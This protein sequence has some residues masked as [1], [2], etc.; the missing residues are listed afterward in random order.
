MENSANSSRILNFNHLMNKKNLFVLGILAFLIFVFF[1]YLVHKD[2]FTQFDFDNTVKLQDRIT[3]RVDTP[4]STLSLLGSFEISSLFLL[5]LVVIRR[6]ISAI[7]I[8]IP[9]VM[10]IL[11]ELYGK[12]FVIH[13]GPPYLFLRNDIPFNFPS[14]YV[15]PGSSY[16]SGHSTRTLFISVVLIFMIA[17]SKK[18]SGFQKTIFISL[19][20][21]FDVAMLVSRV[22]LGEHWTSDVVGGALL[23]SGFG[24][25]SLIAF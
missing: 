1:S 20:L 17:N 19:A 8:F 22:Y 11:L 5:F 7:F 15:Q 12:I 2:L 13:P 18:L 10:A 16:P 6:K 14:S 21:A 24:L 9:Y 23:G 25:I 4:F 3:R